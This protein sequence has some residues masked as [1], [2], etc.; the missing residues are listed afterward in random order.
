V[1]DVDAVNGKA[2]HTDYVSVMLFR[3]FTYFHS[4]VTCNDYRNMYITI[5]SLVRGSVT[6]SN[7]FWI[8]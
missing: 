7:G 8:G 1:F 4:L 5:L 3:L 6:N 2:I